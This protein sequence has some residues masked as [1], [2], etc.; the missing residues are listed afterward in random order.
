MRKIVLTLL[1]IAF[2][3]PAASFAQ[4]GDLKFGHINVSEL[5]S[6]MPERDSIR[7]ELQDYQKMLQK[8]MQTMQQEYTQ[9]LQSYQKNRQ[10]YSQLV[11]KSKEQELQDM[12]TRIQEFQSTAQQDMQ[13]KQ[14]ELLQPL[15][16]KINSAIKRV[17]QSHGYIYIFDTSAGAVV[18]KSEQSENVMPLVKEELGIQ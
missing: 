16:E 11:R 15:M 13:Q 4:S 18:Y 6:M 5:M 10:Q 7:K 17:G 14:Q 9:K 8:E 1:L 12:Q 2:V 3:F